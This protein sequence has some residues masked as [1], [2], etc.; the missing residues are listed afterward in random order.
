MY[1]LLTST[2]YGSVLWRVFFIIGDSLNLVVVTRVGDQRTLW[3]H[4]SL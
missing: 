3:T 1:S 2:V 4:E